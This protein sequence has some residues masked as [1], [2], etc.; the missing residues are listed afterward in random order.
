MLNITLRTLPLLSC[1]FLL[2]ACT[3]YPDVPLGPEASSNIRQL[4]QPGMVEKTRYLPTQ[5]DMHP[6]RETNRLLRYPVFTGNLIDTG[7]SRQRNSVIPAI[8][9]IL[10]KRPPEP[11]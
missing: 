1:C 7:R 11:T 2:N 8:M 6:P 3:D 9:P 10:K 5:K 4:Q